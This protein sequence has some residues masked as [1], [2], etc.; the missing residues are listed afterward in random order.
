MIHRFTWRR[1][2]DGEEEKSL[3]D[4]ID[5]DERLRK[6]VLDAKVVRGELEG[7]DHYAVT[8]CS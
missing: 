3:I 4:Y 5:V 6:V 8:C 1:K 7:S 2:E